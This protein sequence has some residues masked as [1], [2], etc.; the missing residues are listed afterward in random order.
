MIPILFD[1]QLLHE[2]S[3]TIKLVIEIYGIELKLE[4]FSEQCR[5]ECVAWGEKYSKPPLATQSSSSGRTLI[6]FL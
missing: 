5:T 1:G 3:V 6:T 2:I 4:L